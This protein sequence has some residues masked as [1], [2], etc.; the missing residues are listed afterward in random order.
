LKRI[1]SDAC[2]ESMSLEHKA[3]YMQLKTNVFAMIGIIPRGISLSR[4]KINLTLDSGVQ[5][6]SLHGCYAPCL[7][8]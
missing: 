5:I 2:H 3:V 7:D 6:K 1:K 4:I 8:R